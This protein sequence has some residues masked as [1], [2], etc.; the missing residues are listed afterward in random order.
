MTS[1]SATKHH[2]PHTYAH[3][4][5]VYDT[6]LNQK[7]PFQAPLNHLPKSPTPPWVTFPHFLHITKTATPKKIHQQKLQHFH[8]QFS[9]LCIKE[10]IK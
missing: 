8:H 1:H 6:S 7:S 5:L 10:E 9:H 2:T 3:T 4:D